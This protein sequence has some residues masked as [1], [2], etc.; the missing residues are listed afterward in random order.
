MKKICIGCLLMIIFICFMGCSQQIDNPFDELLSYKASYIGDAS[1]V[2]SIIRA[3][4]GSD[5]HNGIE[6]Q[7]ESEPYGLTIRYDVTSPEWETINQQNLVMYNSAALFALVDNVS[8]I[9]YSFEG[10]KVETLHILRTEIEAITENDWSYY[11]ESSKNWE[12]GLYQ[13]LY[14]EE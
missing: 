10:E 9:T 5:C 7:T 4:P 6:L 11:L 12:T 1:A 2:G 3:L 14:L 8:S 13:Q